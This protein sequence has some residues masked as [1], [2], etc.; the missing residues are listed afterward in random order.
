MLNSTYASGQNGVSE[1]K[2]F[3]MPEKLKN[4]TGK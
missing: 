2:S 1:N 4:W 3:L